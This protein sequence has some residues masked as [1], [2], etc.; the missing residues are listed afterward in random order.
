MSGLVGAA[1]S[2]TAISSE[3]VRPPSAAAANS[4]KPPVTASMVVVRALAS[5][6]RKKAASAQN[7]DMTN[8]SF[9]AGC[10]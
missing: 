5:N 3:P 2:A 8:A 4:L 7:S 6:P 1:R 10:A 9:I